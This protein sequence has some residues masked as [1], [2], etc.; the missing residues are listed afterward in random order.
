MAQSGTEKKK[1][2]EE[3]GRGA[4]DIETLKEQRGGMGTRPATVHCALLRRARMSVRFGGARVLATRSCGSKGGGRPG[5]GTT[6]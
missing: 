2:R 4:L 5:G 1:D 6:P 3:R